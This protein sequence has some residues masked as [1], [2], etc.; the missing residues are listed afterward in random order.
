M[1]LQVALS[2]YIFISELD[3]GLQIIDVEEL[4]VD[5][6]VAGSFPFSNLCVELEFKI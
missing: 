1:A 3:T 2:R 5:F 6:Y 4:D